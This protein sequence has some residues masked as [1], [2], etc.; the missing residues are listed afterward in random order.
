MV[1]F[2]FILKKNSVKEKVHDPCF[3][4]VLLRSL[5]PVSLLHP[6]LHAFINPAFRTHT[7]PIT[8]GYFRVMLTHNAVGTERFSV[9]LYTMFITFSL[10]T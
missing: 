5:L 8:I 9:F 10:Q 6:F 7:V 2:P 3:V 1:I 4:A